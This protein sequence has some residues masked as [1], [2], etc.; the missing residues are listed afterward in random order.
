MNIS[1][2]K[3]HGL[4]NDFIVINNINNSLN[5]KEINIQKLSNRHTGIGFDQM[6]VLEKT[7]HKNT[8]YKYRI[9]NANGSEVQ[10]CGNGARCLALYL[11]ERNI[12]KKSSFKLETING[13][14]QLHF[15]DQNNIT[16]NMG[17][18]IFELDQIPFNFTSKSISYDINGYQMGV[19]SMGNPHAVI[20]SKNI[21]NIDI[22]SIAE[23]IQNSLY[24]PDSVNVGFMEVCSR[25]S[26]N[27]R[28]YERGVGETNACGSGACA[29]V[30][31]G[32]MKGVLDQNVDVRLNGG[33]LK[34]NYEKNND[35]MMTGP[36]ETVFE[37]TINI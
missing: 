11:K 21:K 35:V 37:G 16:V 19:L 18:P 30:V 12:I 33:C 4:G 9:F 29:A 5:L 6:L 22:S 13:I 7:L 28:V 17:K 8:D 32:R 26:I 3:M 15:L 31:Y 1:F 23:D 14:I 27:L 20:I 24:F 25:S 10:Q 34:I 36:A 2:T